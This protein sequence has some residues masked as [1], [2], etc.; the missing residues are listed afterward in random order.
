MGH[1]VLAD[2][3]FPVLGAFLLLLQGL[4]QLI[5]DIAV[6]IKPAVADLNTEVRPEG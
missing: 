2:Q 4:A 6:V 5:K 1:T 3:I